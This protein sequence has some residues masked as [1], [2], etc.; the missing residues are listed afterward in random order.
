MVIVSH[1]ERVARKEF[2][3]F[4][5]CSTQRAG[6]PAGANEVL[7]DEA[8]G[9]DWPTLCKCDC[10][11]SVLRE[12]IGTRRGTVTLARRQQIVETIIQTHGW[13]SL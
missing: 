8:D 12:D 13:R 4:V 11:Y 7:L 1:P 2:V 10:I 5:D 9:L 6:R 3:E